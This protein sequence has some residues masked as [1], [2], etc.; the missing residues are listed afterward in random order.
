MAD[1]AKITSIHSF[2]NFHRQLILFSEGSISTLNRIQ[3]E[4]HRRL[5]IIENE[6]PARWK[7]LHAQ[8]KEDLRSGQNTLRSVHS[9]SARFDAIQ[10][11]KKA[12]DKN[13]NQFFK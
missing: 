12:K 9:E 13:L 6:L 8:A 1:R 4:I 10:R 11:I 7:R 3:T 5:N 2:E